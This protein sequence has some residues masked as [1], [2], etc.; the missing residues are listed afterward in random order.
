MFS[1][2]FDTPLT[3]LRKCVVPDKFLRKVLNDYES[4][5]TANAERSAHGGLL[6][7][8]YIRE[9]TCLATIYLPGF[10]AVK[11]LTIVRIALR[12]SSQPLRRLLLVEAKS[13]TAMINCSVRLSNGRVECSSNE[14]FCENTNLISL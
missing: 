10:L 12:R 2:L 11:S 9:Y 14:Q 8:A 4:V 1:L 7:I 5:L 13:S 3:D 6:Y